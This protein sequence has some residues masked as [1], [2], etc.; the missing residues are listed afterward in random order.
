MKYIVSFICLTLVHFAHAQ[1]SVRLV[2]TQAATKQNEDIYVAGNFNSWNP[3]DE[4]YK[5]KPF[6]GGRK[7]IVIKDLAAGTYAFKF[8][9]GNFEKV[10]CMADGR[11]IEDRIIEVNGDISQE[12]T[13]AGWKDDYPDKPNNVELNYNDDFYVINDNIIKDLSQKKSGLHLLH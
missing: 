10:E 4:K 9:R 7:S 1:Y 11:N 2:V 6:A 12:F 13:V 5:L 8:T 3:A